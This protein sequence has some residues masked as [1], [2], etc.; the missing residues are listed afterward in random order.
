[1]AVLTVTSHKQIRRFTT[2]IILSLRLQ[3]EGFYIPEGDIK[4][5]TDLKVK[6]KNILFENCL[7][8]C[9]LAKVRGG[10]KSNP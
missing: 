8:D 3:G 2:F 1:M 7:I 9:N 6:D 10:I 4:V 5:S